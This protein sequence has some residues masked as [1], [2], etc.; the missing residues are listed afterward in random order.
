MNV[1][2]FSLETE[3]RGDDGVVREGSNEVFLRMGESKPHA[4]APA[5]L[6]RQLR[7]AYR[8]HTLNDQSRDVTA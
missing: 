7:H 8:G 2:S 5:P 4:T 6:R 1:I 3:R